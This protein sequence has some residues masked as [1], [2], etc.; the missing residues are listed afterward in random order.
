MI[1]YIL[2]LNLLTLKLLKNQQLSLN[3]L[4]ETGANITFVVKQKKNSNHIYD[5]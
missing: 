2:L 1:K 3:S 4:F 5:F